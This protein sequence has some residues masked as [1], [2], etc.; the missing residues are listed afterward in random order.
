MYR[1]FAQS[2]CSRTANTL[3]REAMSTNTRTKNDYSLVPYALEEP[4]LHSKELLLLRPHFCQEKRFK[5]KFSKPSRAEFQSSPVLPCFIDDNTR[6]VFVL[7]SSRTPHCT[8]MR[9]LIAHLPWRRFQ[10]DHAQKSTLNE[11]E[12]YERQLILRVSYRE[13]NNISS[14]K[15][16][17]PDRYDDP[18]T[19]ASLHAEYLDN[20]NSVSCSISVPTF[21]E[22]QT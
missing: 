6:D 17:S 9:L 18:R 13:H 4:R 20:S 1:L 7:G 12:Y 5:E 8:T 16:L 11:P 21:R 10:Q 19:S 22:K 15:P 14:L 2:A 3:R